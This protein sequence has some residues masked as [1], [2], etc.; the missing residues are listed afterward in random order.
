MSG[1]SWDYFYRSLDDV[2]ERLIV[3]KDPLRRAFGKHLK[4]CAK[5]MQA[6]EWVDSNDCS[7]PDDSD[8]I[9]KALGRDAPAL[10]L[11]EATLEAI[12]ARDELAQL[13]EKATKA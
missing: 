7:P 1:G 9:R 2:S 13:I 3:S 4:E 6:I 8:A 11:R 5:A 10:E 12:R